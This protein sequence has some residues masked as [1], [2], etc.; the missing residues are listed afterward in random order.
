[1]ISILCCCFFRSRGKGE[2]RSPTRG[3]EQLTEIGID[4][5]S[6]GKGESRSPARGR[7]Q[8]TEIGIDGASTGMG[9][10]RSPA[11]GRAQLTEF[12]DQIRLIDGASTDST[13]ARE[14]SS[15]EMEDFGT[16]LS[17]RPLCFVRSSP[18]MQALITAPLSLPTGT[19]LS[20]RHKLIMR[21]AAEKAAERA[22]AEKAVAEKAA[23]S[24]EVPRL[25]A[26][27]FN[28]EEHAS[29]PVGSVTLT[30]VSNSSAA[31]A[32][33]EAARLTA[34]AR[35]IAQY[36]AGG[37]ERR[38]DAD[39][40]SYTRQE[41]EEYYRGQSGLSWEAKWAAAKP[42]AGAPA[43]HARTQASGDVRVKTLVSGSGL[44]VGPTVQSI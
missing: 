42:I 7:A 19:S 14:T 11:R 28:A 37:A 1:M 30:A 33:L 2:S 35:P 13:T 12:T 9:E 21:A 41:F 26:L 36:P 39:G 38:I 27:P 23:A 25:R 8:L 20:H 31:H 24:P 29:L 15:T 22:A 40:K 43:L 16:S 18:R 17:Y 5:A 10:T 44:A 4:G 32:T 3:R 34:V 6:T